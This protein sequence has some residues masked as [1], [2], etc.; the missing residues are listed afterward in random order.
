MKAILIWRVTPQ[1]LCQATSHAT[2]RR[3]TLCLRR[4]S[5]VLLYLSVLLFGRHIVGLILS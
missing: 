5:E 2:L 4:M 3:M 1:I